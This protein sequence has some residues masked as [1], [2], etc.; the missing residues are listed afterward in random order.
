MLREAVGETYAVQKRAYY[1]IS[2]CT[3]WPILVY[4]SDRKSVFL[5]LEICPATSLLGIFFSE[6]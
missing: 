3:K 1:A 2:A 6:H 4:L 5:A